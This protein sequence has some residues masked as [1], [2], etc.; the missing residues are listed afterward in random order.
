MQIA[1]VNNERV[2]AF[3]GGRGIRPIYGNR[4]NC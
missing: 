1:L 4:D 3:E 2:E